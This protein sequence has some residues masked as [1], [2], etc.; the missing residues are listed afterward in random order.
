[1]ASLQPK[2]IAVEHVVLMNEI[3]WCDIKL[4]ISENKTCTRIITDYPLPTLHVV[5]DKQQ[6]PREYDCS[7]FRSMRSCFSGLYACVTQC[8]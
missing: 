3:C 6:L 5:D 2:E 7:G 1:M 8:K 4:V